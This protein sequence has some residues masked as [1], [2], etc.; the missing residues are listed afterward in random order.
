[1]NHNLSLRRVV[2]SFELGLRVEATTYPILAGANP[3]F[4]V[5]GGR[6]LLHDIFGVV[7]TQLQAAAELM[8]WNCNMDVGGDA[9]LSI[10]SADFTGDIVGTQ[11]LFPAAAGGAVTVGAGAYLRLFPALGWVVSAGTID[12]DGDANTGGILWALFYTP[13][14][15]DAVVTAS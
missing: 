1:M 9:A 5:T 7:T 3:V 15:D 12:L 14:D 4:D 13:I 10:D 8:L 6:I 11:Y 2:T